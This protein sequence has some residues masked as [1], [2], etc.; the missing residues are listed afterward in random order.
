M[1]LFSIV[2]NKKGNNCSNIIFILLLEISNNNQKAINEEF[3][4]A[5]DAHFKQQL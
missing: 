3:S 4:R 2:A 1:G 5:F